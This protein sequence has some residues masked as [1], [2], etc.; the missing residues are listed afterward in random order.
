MKQPTETIRQGEARFLTLRATAQR[1]GLSPATLC[2]LRR[3]HKL[4][5]PCLRGMAGGDTALI[6]GHRIATRLV[7]FH[8]Q[9]LRL[10]ESVLAGALTPDEALVRW[11]LFKAKMA[12]A[13]DAN[14]AP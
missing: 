4:Y 11:R 8:I 3:R 10:F 9:Q 6:N 12:I 7:R 14:S 5:E 2:H 1:L 13:E